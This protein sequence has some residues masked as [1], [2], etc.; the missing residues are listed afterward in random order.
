[1]PQ[2]SESIDHCTIMK[3]P[4]PPLN[5]GLFGLRIDRRRKIGWNNRGSVHNVSCPPTAVQRSPERLF[6]RLLPCCRSARMLRPSHGVLA[7]IV[8]VVVVV[9][10]DMQYEDWRVFH[11]SIPGVT[12][13][14]PGQGS[15]LP[16]THWPM[17][18]PPP[19]VETTF[20]GHDVKGDSVTTHAPVVMRREIA[21]RAILCR[22]NMY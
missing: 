3:L 11:T 20:E 10:V 4:I 14:C 1:M 22:S 15:G 5:T 19:V 9:I 16:S 18:T 8:V 12:L 17:L 6:G 13:C 2:Y 7:A 21:W